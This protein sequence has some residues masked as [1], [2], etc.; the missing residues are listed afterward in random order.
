ML[1]QLFVCIVDTKLLEA[2]DFKSLEAVNVQNSDEFV[3][4]AACPQRLVDLQDDP[5]KKR[6]VNAFSES[7]PRKQGLKINSFRCNWISL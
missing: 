4:F 3:S 5:V 7:V 1:L 2:V 6:G